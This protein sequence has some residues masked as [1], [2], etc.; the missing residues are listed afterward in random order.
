MFKDL[1]SKCSGIWIPEFI[2]QLQTLD[3]IDMIIMSRITFFSIEGCWASVESY[4]PFTHAE[5]RTIQLH[6][7]DLLLKGWIL[8]DD[9]ASNRHKFYLNMAKIR[10]VLGVKPS[11][12]R[13]ESDNPL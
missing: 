13:S 1:P 6:L 8:D 4:E 9:P 11:S 7:Q 10:K 5:K 2:L 3:A 12:S